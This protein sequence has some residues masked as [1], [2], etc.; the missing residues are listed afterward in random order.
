MPDFLA[1]Y[2]LII[3][4]GH[5][6]SEARLE[7]PDEI[8]SNYLTPAI[9]EL[10]NIPEGD[11]AGQVFHEFAFF[12]DQQLQNADN[13]EDY[14]RIKRLRERK[15]SEVQELENMI[16]S[17]SSQSREKDN[18]KAHRLKAKQWFDLDDREFQRLKDSRQVFLRQS[19]ENY[20]LS[21]KACDTYDSDALRFST[22][23]LEHSEDESA[24]RA[25]AK[26]I[27]FVGSRKFAPLINQWTSRLLD[28]P[29]KFQDL[30]ASLVLRICV[31]H[32]YHGMYQ[33]FTSSKSKSGKDQSALARTAA[34]A[35][36]IGEIKVN[37]RAAP[38][39]QAIHN[40]NV[41]FH[42]FAGEKVDDARA[43]PGAKVLMRKFPVGLRLE[44]EPLMHR[45]PPPTMKI[46]LRADCGYSDTPK[47]TK[48]HS[49][50]SI[51]SG[52]SMPKILTVLA[53]DGRKYKQLVSLITMSSATVS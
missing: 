14:Q 30:L 45:V 5:R 13:L 26:N 44:Q 11:E 24:N 53:S 9:K 34:A 7:K 16:K 52:I 32:P 8:I 41:L 19:L 6:I 36:I 37:K 4:Q 31:D 50:F 40:T 1:Q 49:E 18:L 35:K 12:C 15:E 23:W 10:H 43:K 48:F 27:P 22:L 33:I 47:I 46:R 51:A 38:F 28:V 29:G 25:V 39:W 2:K 17:G 20:L 21:L 3:I 42:R